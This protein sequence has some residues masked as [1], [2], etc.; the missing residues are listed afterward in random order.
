[1][2]NT[3]SRYER[4]FLIAMLKYNLEVT[5]NSNRSLEDYEK[6]YFTKVT[7]DYLKNVALEFCRYIDNR[8]N[9]FYFIVVNEIEK[10]MTK[11]TE[12]EKLIL[13]VE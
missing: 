7:E 4:T 2:K 9:D 6:H 1:M 3:L 11:L 10:F 13:G 12:N 8:N 5:K